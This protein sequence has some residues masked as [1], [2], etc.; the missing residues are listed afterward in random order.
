MRKTVAFGGFGRFDRA[1]NDGA[2]RHSFRVERLRK[3]AIFVHH[4]R[5]QGLVERAP[6]DTDAHRAAVLN[7]GLDHDPE[8]VVV[9]LADIY[10]AGIDAVFGERLRHVGVFL[11]KDVSVIVEITDN[12]DANPEFVE[13]FNDS[14]HGPRG[15]LRVDRN[16]DKL[17]AGI[18]ER[19]HLIDSGH[20]VGRIGVGHRLDHDGVW[21]ADLHR[22]DTDGHGSAP[23]LCWHESSKT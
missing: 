18:G 17:R 13:G 22:A 16:A 3:P 19:H 10:V 9:F 4:A 21:S 5:E 2:H 11:E 8:I 7:R 15:F 12:R 6:I 20:D 23:R 1:R 14:R